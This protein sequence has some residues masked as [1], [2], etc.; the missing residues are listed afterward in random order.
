M[1]EL[2]RLETPELF[3]SISDLMFYGPCIDCMG[4]RRFLVREVREARIRKQVG[5]ISPQLGANLLLLCLNSTDDLLFYQWNDMF[6]TQFGLV[7]AQ[8]PL[9]AIIANQAIR[10]ESAQFADP[11]YV[12]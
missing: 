8:I 10:G 4:K 7:K 2:M 6:L 12:E 1:S 3:I 5:A 9:M 11:Y